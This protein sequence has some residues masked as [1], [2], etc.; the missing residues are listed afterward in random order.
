MSMPK[1]FKKS[2][3]KFSDILSE[4][5]SLGRFW[6]NYNGKKTLHEVVK[7]FVKE[8][9]NDEQP[10]LREFALEVI[11]RG[12]IGKKLNEH[13]FTSKNR[14]LVEIV[15]TEIL[16]YNLNDNFE[17]LNLDGSEFFTFEGLEK[18]IVP[19]SEIKVSV[20]NDSGGKFEFNTLLR[21]DTEIEAEYFYNGGLLPFVLRKMVRE[22][23]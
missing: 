11:G 9:P 5:Q 16:E 19:N 3:R 8:H 2:T 21:I 18:N 10:A 23:S 17:N 4:Q 7:H 14:K 15:Q 12:L 1:G 22:A 20:R 6:E 13:N